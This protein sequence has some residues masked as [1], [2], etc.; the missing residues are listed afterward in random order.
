MNTR[1]RCIG[2]ISVGVAG[3]PCTKHQLLSSLRA[4]PFYPPLR[5][6]GLGAA[7]SHHTITGWWTDDP[8]KPTS[9]DVSSNPSLKDRLH[10][11]QSSLF[12]GD[13]SFFYQRKNHGF[14]Q[15]SR[16]HLHFTMIF[17]PFYLDLTEPVHQAEQKKKLVAAIQKLRKSRIFR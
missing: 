13:M 2:P 8:T 16:I 7:L 6:L 5:C 4:N 17:P 3:G 9:V 15:N 11:V 1:N 12:G 10:S 14:H